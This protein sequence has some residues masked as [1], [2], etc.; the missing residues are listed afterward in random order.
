[1]RPTA[2]TAGHHHSRAADR[3]RQPAPSSAGRLIPGR[4]GEPGHR[5]H[6]HGKQ[7]RRAPDTTV[8]PR[9]TPYRR[10]GGPPPLAGRRPPTTTGAV[11]RRTPH[12]RPSRR[13]G[14]PRARPRQAAPPSTGHH[15]RP[16]RHALP[17]SRR[18]TTTR[19]PPTA[20]DNRRRRAPDA[21]FPAVAASR[22]TARTATASS[23]AEHRTPR[24]APAPRP[25]AV[26]AGHHH[27]RAADRP[28][29]PAPSSAGRLIP[30]RRGEPG[31]RAHGH[32]KQLRR[33]PDTTVGPRAT[34]Y[35]RH[36]GPPPLAGRR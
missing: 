32:G 6:G 8:G 17:P 33:A 14:P 27:S 22:A 24:S 4:R 16:P 28:R 1:P 34:P 9:A 5:A 11:E 23:S 29:Q 25:I 13:A 36:G 2:V 21:S 18:A 12:S 35:R 30:G 10:H 19:G 15:G 7:L 3:P 26:T 20:H 31:H